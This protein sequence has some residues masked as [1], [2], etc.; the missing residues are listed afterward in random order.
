MVAPD[1]WRVV[2]RSSAPAGSSRRRRRPRSCRPGL[3]GDRSVR[4]VWHEYQI[5]ETCTTD[6]ANDWWTA[7]RP[8]CQPRSGRPSRP[9]SSRF[10][11]ESASS[12]ERSAA[13][14]T[15]RWCRETLAGLGSAGTRRPVPG[16]CCCRLPRAPVRG[17]L[18]AV[19][20]MA[21]LSRACR[22]SWNVRQSQLSAVV[23]SQVWQRWPE[24]ATTLRPR[25]VGQAG[26]DAR[27]GP[28]AW[29]L[30]WEDGHEKG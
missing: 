22:R 2:E 1:P 30:N 18:L 15:S 28:A 16:G 5:A 23:D 4:D 13:G 14:P 7:A 8:R 24:A 26:T 29:L 10:G 11:G 12:S 27:L 17:T 20:G 21:T 19:C 9:T 6:G 3:R 25:S